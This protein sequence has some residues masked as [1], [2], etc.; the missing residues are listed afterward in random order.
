LESNSK[1]ELTL[2]ELLQIAAQEPKEKIE[3][4]KMSHA[5]KFALSKGI[6]AGETRIQASLVYEMYK[7]WAGKEAEQRNKFFNHFALLFPKGRATTFYYYLLNPEPFNLDD[8]NYR[9]QQLKDA[10]KKYKN[11]QKQSKK[12][13]KSQE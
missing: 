2:E 5:Q 13:D 6:K 8:N 4:T 12:K 9:I 3:N 7:T 10:T 11:D 1:K